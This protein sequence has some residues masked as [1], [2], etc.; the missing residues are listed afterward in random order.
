MS[1]VYFDNAAA[2]PA[3]ITSLE[4]FRN[5]ALE[6]PA[7]QEAGHDA[8]YLVR[9]RLESAASE[10]AAVLTGDD[11]TTVL[12]SHSGTD[13]ICGVIAAMNITGGNIITSAVEHPALLAALRRTPAELRFVKVTQNGLIDMENLG[14]LI[15]RDTCLAALHHVQSE[16]GII[17]DPVAIR[18]TMNKHSP[19]AKL[20]LDTIQSAGKIPLPWTA[21]ELD[22]VFVSGHKI[23]A[24]GGAA[25]LVRNA[26]LKQAY[27]DLRQ[28][29]YV[30]GRV[31]PA[32]ILTMTETIKR[33]VMTI[34][35]N[36]EKV[37]VL[38]S[39]LRELLIEMPEK[40]RPV[41]T[42]A[43]QQA[44][45]YI[46][47]CR[48]PGKQ[49]AVIMRMLSETGFAVSSGSACAAEAGGPSAALLAMGFKRDDAYSGLRISFSEKNK[50]TEVEA[51]A[52]ALHNALL[53][54]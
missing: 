14:K 35:A 29:D 44:S 34:A 37:S 33:R 38:N 50:I 28:R 11:T 15:D 17:Q 20:M 26:A 49:S 21:A 8:G 27:S 7:N 46:L 41:I 4:D 31:E 5:F 40:I 6:F 23:G 48:L 51:F 24:P 9:K 32:A 30:T 13:A 3:E 54:Y 18:Q 52:E 10:L 43:S 45:P 16:T 25:A 2:M 53:E 47:H 19:K 22:Y 39:R 42:I 36:S 12:W 1:I